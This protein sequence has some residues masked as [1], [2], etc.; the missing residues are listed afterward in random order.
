MVKKK[1]CKLAY[2]AGIIDGEGCIRITK[3]KS[4]IGN[5]CYSSVLSFRM[6]AKL[7]AELFKE[8]FGTEIYERQEKGKNYYGIIV[9]GKNLKLVLK[10]LLP[11][12]LVKRK[13]A[14][15]TLRL[16]SNREKFPPKYLWNNGKMIGS[17]PIPKEIQSYREKLF[18][19][20]DNFK[21]KKICQIFS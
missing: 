15:Y 7:P 4:N 14:I 1:L 5:I 2:L 9:R 20:V 12:L 6:Q 19:L 16:L 11:Y 17:K 10:Q 21:N 13:E 3:T 8:I 18:K